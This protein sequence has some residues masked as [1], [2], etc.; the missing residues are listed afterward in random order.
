MGGDPSADAEQDEKEPLQR[1][2]TID[3]VRV[4]VQNG[5]E[6]L[7]ET[8][9]PPSSSSENS[10]VSNQFSC[11]T[12]RPPRTPRTPGPR[13]ALATPGAPWQNTIQLYEQIDFLQRTVTS[14]QVTINSQNNS[15]EVLVG[16]LQHQQET[17]INLFDQHNQQ[18]EKHIKQL[19]NKCEATEKQ[20]QSKIDL[21][22]QECRAAKSE[23]NR[24]IQAQLQQYHQQYHHLSQQQE[25]Q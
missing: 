10:N 3:E 21:L 5:N 13:R 2:I 11:K 16:Q 24:E 20:L 8:L 9:H 15:I 4:E 25:Q 19:E 7:K 22:H 17:Y 14:Q 6:I 12:P 1:M 23:H 18:T